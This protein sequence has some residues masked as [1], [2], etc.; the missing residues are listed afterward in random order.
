[1]TKRAR[2]AA[3][4]RDLLADLSASG[5]DGEQQKATTRLKQ[6]RALLDDQVSRVRSQRTRRAAADSDQ[7]AEEVDAREVDR[8]LIADR[9]KRAA[10]ES[11]GLRA[12]RPLADVYEK[13]TYKLEQ[14]L[15]SDHRRRPLTCLAL[16]SEGD[17]LF[18]ADKAGLVIK[19]RRDG[20]NGKWRKQHVFK[21]RSSI[22]RRDAVLALAISS[23]GKYLAVAQG[24]SI[25]LFDAISNKALGECGPNPH[26]APVTGL[27]F[28][29]ASYQL[30]SA[31]V[32]R[33]VK[34]WAAEQAAYFDTVFGHQDQVSGIAA[35]QTAD[36]CI[37]AGARDRTLRLWKI[38]ED[39]QLVFRQSE[40]QGGS[41]DSVCTVSTSSDNHY[42]C[43]GSSSGSLSLWYSGKKKPIDTSASGHVSNVQS[44][45][46]PEVSDVVF[47]GSSDGFLKVWRATTDGELELINELPIPG[48]ITGIAATGKQL[49]VALSGEP[50]DG[51]WTVQSS[52]RPSVLVFSVN[53]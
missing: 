18:S 11:K 43:S 4:E 53:N 26:R 46:S 51:R 24:S 1:M 39:S 25:L 22:G 15:R 34:I 28:Q 12:F 14:V 50:R 13:A 7:D 9:L 48:H 5:S 32:D 17:L 40:S 8:A 49:Y 41:I 3:S 16:N 2:P 47:S 6:A 33:T 42:F 10:I 36:K 29:P 20:P 35:L 23:D 21:T 52:I 45:Y 44:L 31:S 27:A 30:Y 37:T 19:W 38:A